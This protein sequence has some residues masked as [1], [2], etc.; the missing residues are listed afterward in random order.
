MGGSGGRVPPACGALLIAP[1]GQRNSSLWNPI[2]VFVRE[3]HKNVW[4]VRGIAIKLRVEWHLSQS[5]GGFWES[6]NEDFLNGGSVFLA[7]FFA[8]SGKGAAESF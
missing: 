1:L 3:A 8:E 6:L 4:G 2:A 5:S 7:G